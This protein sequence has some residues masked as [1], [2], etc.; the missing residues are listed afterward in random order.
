M[1]DHDTESGTDHAEFRQY[2][3]TQGQWMSPDPYDGSYD[4][5]NPQSFNRYA[6]VS[7]NPL[8][9]IDPSGQCDTAY[10]NGNPCAAGNLSD[11]CPG[12]QD[13]RSNCAFVISAACGNAPLTPTQ[14]GTQAIANY[15]SYSQG[16]GD[17]D[18]AA[19]VAATNARYAQ[20]LQKI[21]SAQAATQT[22]FVIISYWRK[23]AGGFGHIGIS[24]D[25]YDTRGFSTLDP[26]TKTLA[27]V[28]GNPDANVEDDIDAH[29]DSNGVTQPVAYLYIPITADQAQAMRD[30]IADVTSDPGNYNMITNNCAQYVE[31]VLHAGGVSGVPNSIVFGPAVLAGWLWF[32]YGK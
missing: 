23:G 19:Y 7:N 21:W 13:L 22:D 4:Q 29:T 27:R 1:L 16:Q 25:S 6:Y 8:T 26:T 32:V 31:N 10:C 2:S 9:L 18:Y 14:I 5:G 17:R 15:E 11:Q 28:F 24:V 30:D 12:S 20:D 3:S